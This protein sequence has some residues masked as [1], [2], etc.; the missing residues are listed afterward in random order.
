LVRFVA[1]FFNANVFCEEAIKSLFGQRYDTGLFVV[2]DRSTARMSSPRL[3]PGRQTDVD[4]L[5]PALEDRRTA[6]FPRTS[7]EHLP[8]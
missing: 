6:P 2:D 3:G 8:T 5:I 1:I 4:V 7:D